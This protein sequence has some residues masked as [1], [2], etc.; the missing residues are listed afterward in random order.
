MNTTKTKK[1]CKFFVKG[2]CTQENC[3][4]EHKEN[5]CKKYF[6]EG[7]C[8]HG[9]KCK[10][11]HVQ[12]LKKRPKNTENFHPDHKKADMCVKFGNSSIDT[13]GQDVYVNDVILVNNFI[14]QNEPKE[15]FG[16]LMNEIEVCTQEN[17]D[18]WKL[19]HGDT[20]LIA[21]DNVSWKEKV[22][23]FQKVID[24]IEKYFNFKTVSTRFN[25]YQNSNHWKPY[26]HDAAA[27]KPHIA[28]KQNTT[29]A[30]SFGAV[31]DA[32]FQ[33]N[34]NKCVVSFPLEDNSVYVF[35]KDVNINWKHG[36]PQLPKEQF[37][38]EKRI[39]IILWGWM[40]QK[41]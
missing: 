1:I 22:P 39:S 2:K 9:T 16:L 36:I 29:I 35:T 15:M 12:T 6:F 31:R 21:D 5:V 34:D 37:N 23:S 19:W 3:Q 30:I 18:L 38:E 4:F 10:F 32:A 41:E 11:L 40:D 13:L 27:I 28:A 17:E 14:K 24:E 8:K 7:K 33:F 26:H 20:H 25:L